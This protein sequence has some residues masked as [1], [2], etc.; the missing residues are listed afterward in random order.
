[1]ANNNSHALANVL[2]NLVNVTLNYQHQQDA[3]GPPDQIGM[4]SGFWGCC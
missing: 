2:S 4:A 3:E 1:M